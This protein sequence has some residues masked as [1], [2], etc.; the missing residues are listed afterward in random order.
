MPPFMPGPRPQPFSPRGTPPTST[1]GNTT[2]N[3]V[4]IAATQAAHTASAALTQRF[5]AA[6]TVA[7]SPAI[8][9]VQLTER[10][11][12]SLTAHQA[13]ATALALLTSLQL[14]QL[15]VSATQRPHAASMSLNTQTNVIPSVSGA[16]F[17]FIRPYVEP[18]QPRHSVAV[19]AVQG[20]HSCRASMESRSSARVIAMQRPHQA[21]AS[22]SADPFSQEEQ[23]LAYLAAA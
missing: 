10:F 20:S 21:V 8:A 15:S 17:V 16:P 14:F 13:P 6:V 19:A 11:V 4:A 12:A 9:S 7:Q 3:P 23:L 22:I 1:L 18:E 5:V 2:L